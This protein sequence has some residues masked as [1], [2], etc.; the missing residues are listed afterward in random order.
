MAKID[1]KDG[2]RVEKKKGRK[3]NV[4]EDVKQK[5]GKIVA[6]CSPRPKTNSSVDRF[7]YRAHYTGTDIHAG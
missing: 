4:W 1:I 7:Q 6:S 3:R 5:G 2:R